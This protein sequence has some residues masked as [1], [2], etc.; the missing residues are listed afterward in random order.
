M[1]AKEACRRYCVFQPRAQSSWTVIIDICDLATDAIVRVC[2]RPFLTIDR[3][4]LNIPPMNMVDGIVYVTLVNARPDS[5]E[6]RR[7]EFSEV[8]MLKA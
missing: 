3:D 4:G 5:D 8:L 1:D 7:R 6:P 2:Q